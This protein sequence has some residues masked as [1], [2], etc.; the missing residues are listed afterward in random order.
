MQLSPPNG[1]AYRLLGY[2]QITD[3]SAA[4]SLTIPAGT[5]VIEM[6]PHTQGVRFRADR[7]DPTASV[8]YPINTNTTYTMT[9]SNPT[10]IRVIQS[11]ANAVLNI[12][13]FGL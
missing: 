5:S 4:V 3:L 9:I 7:T 2:Q 12:N 8:G 11:A 6:M 1:Q 13:Y 10:D